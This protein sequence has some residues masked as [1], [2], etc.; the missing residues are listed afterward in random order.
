M[1]KVK[2]LTITLIFFLFMTG[3]GCER[4]TI[5]EEIC[6][7]NDCNTPVNLTVWRVF[8]DREA[9]DPLIEKYVYK[10]PN[11]TITYRKLDYSEYEDTLVNALSAGR[12]PDIFQIHN[13]WLPRHWDK[14]APVPEEI[15][16]IDEYKEL[17]VDVATDDFVFNDQ[18][19]AM[20]LSVDTLALYVNTAILEDAKIFSPPATWQQFIE[21]S[22]RFTELTPQGNI[23]MS[24]SA[25]GTSSNINRASDIIYALMLQ[26]DTNMTAP[27]NSSASFALPIQTVTGENFYPGQNALE[28]YTNF[29]D[30]NHRNYSWNNDLSGS[31]QAFE[32]GQTVM[33]LN[34]AYQKPVIEKFKKPEVEFDIAPLPTINTTD[35]PVSYANYWAETVNKQ[36]R[37]TAWA[38]HFV[39]FMAENSE[40]YTIRNSKPTALRAVAKDAYEVFDR[41]AY[42]AQSFYKIRA[43][44]VDD[45][46]NQ[47]IDSVVTENIPIDDA[48]DKAQNDVTELMV[49]NKIEQ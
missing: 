4:V 39:N 20:P 18:I 8:E 43:A 34:Y 28:F 46:F 48:L 14:I 1:N 25:M 47:M 35:D 21:Y 17:F 5:P 49:T 26:N 23:F 7:N 13:D 12:G 27:D 38:W 33:M 30:P 9:I 29:A 10:Y 24:G 36:S 11:V 41:Q 2:L 19:Y 45:I 3:Q 44:E 22:N 31:I 40:I 16:T 6:P 15:K 32:N 37:N 42:Y